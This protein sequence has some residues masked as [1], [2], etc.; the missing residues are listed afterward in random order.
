MQL[1][2]QTVRR[3]AYGKKICFKLHMHD[4]S[5]SRTAVHQLLD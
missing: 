2:P 4:G 5:I 1:S 3:S